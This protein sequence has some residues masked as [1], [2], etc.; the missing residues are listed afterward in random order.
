[1]F[2]LCLRK[3]KEN[4]KL[5]ALSDDDVIITTKMPFF[6]Q[7]KTTTKFSIKIEVFY[8]SVPTTENVHLF[9]IL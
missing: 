6:P 1:L 5:I 9:V 7:N 4:D 3:E 2:D 8:A